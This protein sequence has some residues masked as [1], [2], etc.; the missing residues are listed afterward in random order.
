LAAWMSRHLNAMREPTARE[1]IVP[2]LTVLE[3]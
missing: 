1:L 3:D 2:E